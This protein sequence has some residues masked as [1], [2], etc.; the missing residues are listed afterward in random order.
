MVR[1][2]DITNHLSE[3]K[4]AQDRALAAMLTHWAG[5]AE[6]GGYKAI[7][8]VGVCEDSTIDFEI[9]GNNDHTLLIGA[10]TILQFEAVKRSQTVDVMP[11]GGDNVG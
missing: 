6:K 9:S 7:A 10:T 4:R 11:S 2:V 1:L 5:M 8:I 3:E